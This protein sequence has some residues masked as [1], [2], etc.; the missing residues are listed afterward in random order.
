MS[1]S[2]ASLDLPTGVVLIVLSQ[3]GSH[4][5]ALH[6][7][8]AR[9][10]EL[11]GLTDPELHLLASRLDLVPADEHEAAAEG[12]ARIA[13]AEAITSFLTALSQRSAGNALYATY[14]CRETLRSVES[15]PDPAGVVLDLPPF[16]GTLKNYYDHLYHSLGAEAGWVADVVA[17]IDFSVTRTELREI[18]PD[19]AHRV[20][21]AL[22]VLRPVLIE[23]ATQGGVRIYHESFA[24]YLRTPF[25]ASPSALTVLLEQITAWL[26][27]K[28]LLVDPRAFHS[29]LP[30][31][32]DAGK[33]A[34]V[35]DLV[36]S[37]FVTNSVAA[38]FAAS[39]INANLATAVGAATR[40]GQWSTVV[41]YVEQSRA[42]ESYQTE[43]FDSTLVAFADI[44]VA[45]L[46]ADTIATRLVDEDQLTMSARAGLQMCAAVDEL[47][48]AAPWREYIDG[49]LRESEIDNTSYGETSDRVVALAWLRGQLRLAI[50]PDRSDS[51]EDADATG[52]DIGRVGSN[53]RPPI[54]WSRV[55]SWTESHDLPATKVLAA[56][57]DTHGWDGA[58]QLVQTLE[59]PGD[60][61]LAIADELATRSTPDREIGTARLWAIAAFTH[62]VPPGSIRRVL[63]LGADHSDLVS[64]DLAHGREQLFDH[65]RRILDRSARWEE[66]DVGAWL[67]ECAI[68]ARRDPL[69]MSAADAI[70][71]GEGWYRCW[72]RFAIALAHADAAAPMNQGAVAVEALQLLTGDL[73][74]F[75]RDPRSCDLYSLHRLIAETIAHAIA[76]LD[77]NQWREGLR[78][79][80]EVSGSISTTMF[81]EL[82]GPVPP[83]LIL[84]LAVDSATAARRETAE[85][86]ITEEIAQGSGRRFYSDLAE[87]R[88]L[89]ARLALAS[90]DRSEVETLWHQACLF[91]TAYGWHKDITIYEVL[92]PLPELITLDPSAGRLRVA[93][94]QALCE[95]VPLHTDLRETRHAW[96]RWWGLLAKADPVSA[97]HLALPQLLEECNDPNWLLN[98]ALEDVWREWHAKVD[99]LIAGAL[100]LTLDTA[101]DRA[102]ASQLER[103]KDG[104]VKGDPA[105]RRLLIWL[106][107]RAD[108]RPAAYSYT[109]SDEILGKDDDLVAELNAV[110]VAADVPSVVAL[111]DAAKA[112]VNG[113]QA[114]KDGPT[115]STWRA[116]DASGPIEAFPPGLPG[117]ARAIRAWRNR[118]YDIHAPEWAAERFANVIGYRLIGL[119]AENR[120]DDAASALRSLADASGIGERSGILRSIAEGLERHGATRLSALAYALTW[121]RT[122][123]H[124]GWLTFGGETEIE[125]LRR[126]STLDA[127]TATGVVAEEIE[128][129]VATGRY[130]TYGISQAIIYALAVGALPCG[131]GSGVAAAFAAWDEAFGVIAS[132]APRVDE[133][134]D[135]DVPYVPPSPDGGEPAPGD[136][137]GALALAALGGLA[138]PSRG[139]KRRSLLAAELLLQ[140]RPAVAAPAFALTFAHLTDPATLMWLLLV[141]S[142]SDAD[143]SLVV[144]TCQT[145]FRALVT[146]PSLT[147]RAIAR[148]MVQGDPPPLASSSPA[149]AVLLR[150]DADSLWSPDRAED[151]EVDGVP[152][153]DELLESVAG[154]RIRRAE[155]ILDGIHAV[156]R[157]R[158]AIALADEGVKKRLNRQLETLASRV[159]KRWPD[160]FLAPEQAIEEIL[161]SVAA[162]GRAAKLMAGEPVRDPIQWED[163]LASALADDPKVPLILE[164]CRQPRPAVPPP[165]GAG[166]ELWAQARAYA[167]GSL[168]GPVHAAL[169]EE[170]LLVATVAL[171]QP[172]ELPT[173]ERG[174][175][176]GWYWLGIVEKRTVKPTDWRRD[177]DLIAMRY[178]VLEVRDVNDRQALTLPPVAAGDLRLWRAQ[179][180]PISDPTELDSSQPLLGV[181]HD[182]SM[183]SDGRQGLGLPGAILT[184]TPFLIGVLELQPGKPCT[185]HDDNGVGLA[186]VTWRADYDVSDYY[187]AWPRTCGTGVVVR[188]DLIADL[189]AVAGQDRL[190]VRDFVVGDSELVAGDIEPRNVQFDAQ[191]DR[192]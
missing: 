66:G 45:I 105:M 43:R 85:G 91:L 20:D 185:Y 55:A 30:L 175:Y 71:V 50:G 92:D 73:R 5:T 160:A 128:R 139:K 150:R 61:C 153:F 164:A 149:D 84:H 15:Q 110:A 38:G 17:L 24:R 18:R 51:G 86:I 180:D 117:L 65:T 75:A 115:R 56:V 108:E 32:A 99:P 59:K 97:V 39:A 111:R 131:D 94:L 114:W 72:L 54:D 116:D 62:G 35:I 155:R 179:I 152:G 162:G 119:V 135:P 171:E 29:L 76:M 79:L 121:T 190:V 102:D 87:Y 95:R 130:G 107:A 80:K 132:R 104:A 23:R 93:A 27:G 37:Q 109:N 106:L 47:G 156:V 113:S 3:P 182:L 112:E 140:E 48:A 188:P 127:K 184:P 33:D 82:G 88:L 96:S 60:L 10:V 133:S 4:L 69:G 89:A 21:G 22:E 174:P 7:A 161:Q 142:S 53:P 1:E 192:T 159:N 68:A 98:E 169:E 122:R 165:P 170:S 138:H 42:A 154:V 141:L 101:L 78:I 14:I 163:D 46:G 44:P 49:Y 183:V 2:L 25:Q 143:V 16:D 58:L 36:D 124:G 41:R 173:V 6:E 52:K 67:D 178:R 137:E 103:L 26:D 57:L 144:E 191:S 187:L 13:D 90:G 123:G 134:D 12:A 28:G 158:A 120:P 19:A 11:P 186:L 118:P 64:A 147:I 74:P 77:D 40:R 166:H 31:L 151:D 81:G 148:R 34:K 70:V 167:Q 63:A 176:R 146:R 125:S 100:R 181:D 83:D 145:V 136:L 177:S 172:A 157:E 126:A 8:G 168:R 189:V 129:I 9:T